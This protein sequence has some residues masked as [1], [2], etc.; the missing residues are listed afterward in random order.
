MA[1]PP[2]PRAPPATPASIRNAKAP[3]SGVA[4]DI[5]RGLTAGRAVICTP[6]KW[7]LIMAI[8]RSL[9]RG[10]FHKLNI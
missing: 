6:A 8:V 4:A 3:V 9:L 1:T 10:V 5:V 2:S 7:R